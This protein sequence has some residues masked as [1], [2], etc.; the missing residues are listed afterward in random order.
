VP[1]P[2]LGRKL[3]LHKVGLLQVLL[4]AGKLLLQLRNSSCLS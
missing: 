1:V 3:I 2:H 4:A